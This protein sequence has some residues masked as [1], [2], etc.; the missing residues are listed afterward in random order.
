MTV[1]ANRFITGKMKSLRFY[2]RGVNRHKI[3]KVTAHQILLLPQA[4]IEVAR[5]S[6]NSVI[7]INRRNLLNQ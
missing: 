7:S 4:A 6:C 3:K 5:R 1:Y 2:N